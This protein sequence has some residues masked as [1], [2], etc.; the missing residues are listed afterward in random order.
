[1]GIK[2]Q[3]AFVLSWQSVAC[4]ASRPIGFHGVYAGDGMHLNQAPRAR[5]RA[6]GGVCVELTHAQRIESFGYQP[7][8][9]ARRGISSPVN[10]VTGGLTADRSPAVPLIQ[11]V[12]VFLTSRRGSGAVGGILQTQLG[13][14]FRAEEHLAQLQKAVRRPRF[15]A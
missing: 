3:I 2:V 9:T 6:A 15:E 11:T 7:Q 1:M 4:I 12:S 10:A 14:G 13:E 5:A 8:A